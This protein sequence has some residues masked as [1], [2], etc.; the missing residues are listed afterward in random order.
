MPK[1]LADFTDGICENCGNTG[2]AGEPCSVCNSPMVSVGDV[3]EFEAPA[4]D[5][6]ETYSKEVLNADPD[7][8]PLEE[9]EEEEALEE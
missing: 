8:I 1:D 9:A 7:V 3:R 2:L 5:D 6:D 4:G